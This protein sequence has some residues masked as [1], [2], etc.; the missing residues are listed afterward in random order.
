MSVFGVSRESDTGRATVLRFWSSG[1]KYAREHVACRGG[2]NRVN[3]T[4][5]VPEFAQGPTY[6]NVFSF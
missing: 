3:V 5:M 4:V 2:K 1:T 6:V